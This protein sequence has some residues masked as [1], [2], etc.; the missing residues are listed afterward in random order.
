MDGIIIFGNG[1]VTQFGQGK[2][3]L[4]AVRKSLEAVLLQ[5]KEAEVKELRERLQELD[6]A[7]EG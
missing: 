5:I 4:A 7:N 1:A 6:G 3:D 2:L